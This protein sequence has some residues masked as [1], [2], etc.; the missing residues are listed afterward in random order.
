[1][2]GWLSQARR[3]HEVDGG[4]GWL[5]AVWIALGALAAATMAWVI[6]K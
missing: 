3:F 4:P 2:P 5:N 1:M 6:L